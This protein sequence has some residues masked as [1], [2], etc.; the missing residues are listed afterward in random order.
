MRKI[1]KKCAEWKKYEKNLLY[2]KTR[3]K[4]DE[5]KKYEKKIAEWKKYE[6]K[7]CCMKRNNF[8]HGIKWFAKKE[9]F[10]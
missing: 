1:R 6:K 7:N 3:N 4:I 5:W 10:F 9:K 2:G 8:F